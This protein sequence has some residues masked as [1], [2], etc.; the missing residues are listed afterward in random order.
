MIKGDGGCKSNMAYP[1]IYL[2]IDNCF[3]Y[4]RW[5]RPKEWCDRIAQLGIRYVEASADNE[6]DPLF[7]GPEY[8]ACWVEE[9]QK[10]QAATGV[11]VA[12]LYSGH[13]TYTT[14]GLT[15]TDPRVRRRMIDQWFKPMAAAAAQL[16]AGLGFF[17]HAFAHTALQDAVLYREEIDILEQG[18]VELNQYAAAVGCGDIGIEQMYSPHQYPWTIEQMKDLIRSITEKSGRP[19]YFTEDVGHHQRKFQKPDLE[20]LRGMKGGLKR[21]TWLGSD[22]AFALAEAGDWTGL[23]AE[24][25]N[26]PY[27]FAE[28]KDSDCYAWLSELGRYSP[29]I[30]LQQTDGQTSAHLPFT[31]ER[32]SWGIID[33]KKILGSLKKAYDRKEEAGM[34]GGCEKI[35]LTLELFTGTAAIMRDLMADVE[36]SVSYWRQWIPEDGMRLDEL[37]HEENQNEK[38]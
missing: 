22:R 33:G 18:L 37:Y 12:N 29:I 34:P 16:G 32:N 1:K 4:K 9:V 3:A 14:L 27:L 21:D 25:Q 26:T 31:A 15:H 11:R 10:A 38:P 2:A 7:M 24:I 19:F 23:E 5:T 35:Y 20:Q 36:E 13:G 6:L 28:E 17:A 8:L 30:H